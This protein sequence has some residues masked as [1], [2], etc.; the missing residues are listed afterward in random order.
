MFVSL[1]FCVC[2]FLTVLM[3]E[4]LW[5]GNFWTVLS[6]TAYCCCES[7]HG[8]SRT[9]FSYWSQ[10]PKITLFQH[11]QNE[12]AQPEVSHHF[13]KHTERNNNPVLMTRMFMT[14][15]MIG[16]YCRFLESMVQNLGSS[17]FCEVLCNVVHHYASRSFSVYVD[18]IR[19]M[20][21]QK[22]TL[23]NLR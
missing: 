7:F 22:H 15:Y 6:W 13:R 8:L 16:S 4:Y 14:M 11:P 12:R 18:Y 2:V 5:S 23:I 9:K 21:S 10:R 17:L 19:N 3:L 20:P 1:S